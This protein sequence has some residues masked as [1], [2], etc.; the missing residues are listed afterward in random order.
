MLMFRVKLM[1]PCKYITLELLEGRSLVKG[2]WW[3]LKRE[4]NCALKCDEGEWENWALGSP[5][6]VKHIRLY[7]RLDTKVALL[8]DYLSGRTGG[9]GTILDPNFGG[10]FGDDDFTWVQVVTPLRLDRIALGIS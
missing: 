7:D 4:S 6:S 5:G 9:T 2:T 3:R 8:K 1:R 10:A